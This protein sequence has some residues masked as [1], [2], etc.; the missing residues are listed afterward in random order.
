MK[1]L[2]L[3]SLCSFFSCSKDNTK[4]N[5]TI[6]QDFQGGAIFYID[7]TGEHG[8]VVSYSSFEAEWG[9]ANTLISG[10][11]GS[12]I[13]EGQQNTINIINGCS[14]VGIAAKLCANLTDRG[15]TDWYLPSRYE[16]SYLH[17]NKNRITNVSFLNSNWWSSSQNNY[18]TAWYQSFNGNPGS[19]SPSTA[20]KN[21]VYR[22]RAIRAF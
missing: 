7:A 18:G 22:V 13:G 5:L 8:L 1:K 20:L 9:C 2:L 4:P 6:G 11:D 15:Y 12:G 17:L 10:A 3:L 16:L 14:E 19:V 21:Q